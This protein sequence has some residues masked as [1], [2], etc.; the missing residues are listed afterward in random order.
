M[1]DASYQTVRD[2]FLELI[3]TPNMTDTW[4]VVEMIHHLGL[5][6]SDKPDAKWVDPKHE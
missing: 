6:I 2:K 4:V 1:S 3:N 5:R